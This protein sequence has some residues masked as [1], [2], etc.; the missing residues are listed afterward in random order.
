MIGGSKGG[1]VTSLTIGLDSLEVM[2]RKAAEAAHYPILKVKL[3]RGFAEDSERLRLVRAAAPGARLSIDANAGWDVETTRAMLPLLA[4]AGAEVLEQPLAIGRFEELRPLLAGS[5]IPIVA[6]EDAQHLASLGRLE[7]C[8]H[9]INVKLM[10]CG[11][12]A[13]ARL[14][15]A[16]ARERGWKL[17]LGCMV[18]TGIGIAA[19][20]ALAGFADWLDLDGAML[21]SND[22]SEPVSVSTTD[23]APWEVRIPGAPGLGRRLRARAA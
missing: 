13:E 7:G 21:S 4:D 14:M 15:I 23:I 16:F 11:G 22:P 12:I 5:P 1:A 10:K 18:E 20:S 17:L 8:V 9:G 3:G 6:D 2:A 19:A